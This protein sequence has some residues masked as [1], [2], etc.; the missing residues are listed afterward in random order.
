MIISVPEI[1]HIIRY[2]SSGADKPERRLLEVALVRYAWEKKTAPCFLVTA[3]L[4]GREQG[5]H[6]QLLGEVLAEELALLQELGQVPALDFC[7]LAG[8][9]YDYPD[10]HKRGGTGEVTS[11]LNAFAPLAPQTLAVLGNHDEATPTALAPQVTLLDGT[12]AS[13]AGLTVGG[14]GGIVGNPERNQRKSETEFL[15]AVERATRPK[16]DILLLH[17]GPEGPTERH[18]GWSALN[19]QFQY[20]DDLLVVFGH[21]HWPTPFHTE[22][23]NF[24]CNT[25]SRAL[26]FLPGT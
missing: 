19:E 16:A 10:C 9:F 20:E 14:V 3:D 8:D 7:L 18:R 17:Q 2:L 23:T 13:V 11:V 1:I 4:Q 22:G 24:F 21:C 15:R 5:K 6:N 25:D 26:I 12:K